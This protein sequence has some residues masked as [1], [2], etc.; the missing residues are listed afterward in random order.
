MKEQL[1][2]A[3]KDESVVQSIFEA[4]KNSMGQD[5]TEA[6]KVPSLSPNPV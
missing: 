5:I 4:A 3:T 2:E 6:D 1:V